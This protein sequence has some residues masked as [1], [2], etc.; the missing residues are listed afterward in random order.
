VINLQQSI[1]AN[2]V[3]RLEDGGLLG[4]FARQFSS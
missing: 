4:H 1:P 3:E 2:A